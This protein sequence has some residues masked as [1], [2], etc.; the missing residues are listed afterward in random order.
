M[1]GLTDTNGLE[2]PPG[3]TMTVHR[4][5]FRSLSLM[6]AIA[7]GV[8]LAGFASVPD[9]RAAKASKSVIKT[10]YFRSIEIKRANLGPFTK[11]TGMLKRFED[12]KVIV[13]NCK[14]TPT[15]ECAYDNWE[16]L[17]K[18]LS[19][20]SP[21]K[22]IEAVN[23]VMNETRYILDPINWGLE[24]YW[25]TPGQFFYKDGD[26]EDYAIVKYMT[27]RRL[28]IDPSKMRIVVLQDLNLGIAHAVLVV[29]HGNKSLVLDNQIKQVVDAK[30]IRHYK[31]YYSINENAWW[32]HRS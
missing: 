3:T 9:A 17:V 15:Q 13:S 31:P 32:L 22:Q 21:R 20:L 18:K 12:E 16:T 28:G 10:S 27:L 26:C 14:P 1:L 2:D 30:T 8:A 23:K 24:D 11:W 5:P 4:K 6:A 7:C 29:K 19:K 25:A